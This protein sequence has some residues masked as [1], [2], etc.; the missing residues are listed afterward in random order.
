MRVSKSRAGQ[1]RV[2]IDRLTE[3]ERPAEIGRMLAGAAPSEQAT[4]HA[5]EMLRRARA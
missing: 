5:E 2:A 4:A 1:D 3:A